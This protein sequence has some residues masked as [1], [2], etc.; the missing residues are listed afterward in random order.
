[1]TTG[2]TKNPHLTIWT[3]VSKVMTL[4]FN[5]LSRFLVAT[6]PRSKCLL[7][8]CLQSPSTVILKPE[9]MKSDTFHIFPICLPWSDRTRCHD[10]SFWMLSFKPAFSLSSF[11]F[12]KRLLVPLHFLPLEWYHLPIWGYGY[13]S[14][15]SWLQLVIHSAR[16]F[17][18]C[19]L[20][21]S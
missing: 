20:H 10:H 8:S 4:L 6:L 7:I 21:I 3:F 9:K 18:W 2:K 13:F 12:I 17:T 1:M 11:T 16:H 14:L 15:Q 19:T 5:T